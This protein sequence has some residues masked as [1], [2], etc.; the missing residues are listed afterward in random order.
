VKRQI[1]LK[2]L[3]VCKSFFHSHV[4]DVLKILSCQ[5]T[6]YFYPNLAT[7]TKMRPTAFSIIILALVVLA[8]SCRRDDVE[9]QNIYSKDNIVMSGAQEVPANPSPAIGS[10]NVT[11]NR[12]SKTLTYKVTWSNLTDSLL[13]MHIHGLAPAGF[14]ASPAQNIIVAASSFAQDGTAGSGIFPQKTTSHRLNFLKSGTIS[15]SLFVDGVA[16]KE[17]DLLNGLYYMNIHTSGINPN[18][19]TYGGGEIRGQIVFQ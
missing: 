3:S 12:L 7:M 10:M 9:H 11:Y 8:V 17:A 18:G 13:L 1:T 15:G 14:S 2:I 6:S 5:K 16:I 4:K 19:G